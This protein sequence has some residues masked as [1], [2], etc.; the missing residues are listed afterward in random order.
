MN[1]L[2]FDDIY[3]LETAKFMH[4]C[5]NGLLPDSFESYFVKKQ[6]SFNLRSTASNPYR[7][8]RTNTN[9]YK[10]WLVNHG[11]EVWEKLDHVIK[12]LPFCTFKYEVKEKILNDY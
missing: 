8:Q 5:T 6:Y 9:A 12:A 3:F 11:L 1:L 10:R 2:K 4:K 7:K